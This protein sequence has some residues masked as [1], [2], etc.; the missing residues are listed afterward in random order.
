VEWNCLKGLKGLG[1]V[2]LL[3][4]VSHWGWILRFLKPMSDPISLPVACLPVDQDI[5]IRYFSSPIPAML[6]AMIM[7]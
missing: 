1:G 7:D 3:A 4:K 5:A 6:L 2:A